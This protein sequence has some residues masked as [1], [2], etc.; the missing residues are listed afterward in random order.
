MREETC[1][2]LERQ[3]RSIKEENDGYQKQVLETTEEIQ[4][5]RRHV[6]EIEAKLNAIMKE[7][8][9]KDDNLL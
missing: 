6:K 5:K 2:D 7:S 8:Q 9:S 4:E 3:V 1:A